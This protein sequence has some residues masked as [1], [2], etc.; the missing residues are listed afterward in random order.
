MLHGMSAGQGGRLVRHI[1]LAQGIALYVSAILGAGVLVLPGQVASLAGP[2]SLL[3]WTIACVMGASLAWMFAALA[4][5]F[6]D[7]GGVATYVRQAFGPTV[8]GVTGWLYFVAHA[9]HLDQGWAYLIAA[10]IL[11]TA[12]GANL[13]GVRVSSRVQIGLAGGV[14]A[15]LVV[16]IVVALRQMSISRLTPFAPD[17]VTPIGA[18]V[19]V[20]FFAFAGWEAVAHLV[21]E[22]VDPDRDVP[23][24]IVATIGIVTVLYLGVASAVVLT[25][26]Y[27]TE[28]VDHV[29]I[30]LVLQRELGSTAGVAAAAIAVVISLGTA[31]AFVAGVARLAY[32][33]AMAGWLP[34]RAAQATSTGTPVGGVLTVSTV[35]FTGLALA[36]ANGWGTET[37]VVVPATLVVTVYLLAA[38]AAA[39]L[40]RG[41]PR[42]CARAIVKT[43]G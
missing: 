38:A 22:F 4:R 39:R 42:V 21:E 20:L 12:V 33:L 11:T 24:A 1:G 15:A 28:Q 30:G 31:N 18:G 2:A 8:G 16:V 13:L 41:A 19:V 29:A 36:T 3:S 7:A 5:R 14:A 17:G 26:T 9:L 40:L 37:L 25:G 27:G 34:H 10:V 35:A 43:C 32:A 6:P 23:R